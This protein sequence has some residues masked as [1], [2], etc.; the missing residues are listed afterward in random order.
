MSSHWTV[1]LSRT[2]KDSLCCSLAAG[3]KVSSC[4]ILR[5]KK[6]KNDHSAGRKKKS[7]PICK[8]NSGALHI[9][10]LFSLF[11][12]HDADCA[13]YGCTHEAAIR[14]GRHTLIT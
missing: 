10:P 4:A 9:L 8:A 7:D 2:V 5:T 1:S 11:K 13:S 6:K 3:H 14:S 12:M